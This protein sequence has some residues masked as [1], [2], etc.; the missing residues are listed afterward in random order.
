[1]DYKDHVRMRKD[2]TG[3]IIGLDG[4]IVDLK[5]GDVIDTHTNLSTEQVQALI[6]VGLATDN[7]DEHNLYKGNYDPERR[8]YTPESVTH[9]GTLWD[10]G[11]DTLNPAGVFDATKW[12]ARVGTDA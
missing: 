5:C 2:H 7:K 8:Y 3:M 9:N 12:I 10:C 11:Q 4:N 1:M 6:D